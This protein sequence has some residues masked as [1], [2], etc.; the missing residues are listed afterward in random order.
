MEKL[1][2]Q[3]PVCRISFWR[4]A[5]MEA[6]TNIH[7]RNFDC[8]ICGKALKTKFALKIHVEYIHEGKEKDKCHICM[9]EFQGKHILKSHI[10]FVHEGKKP[11]LCSHCGYSSASSNL[12]RRHI[13]G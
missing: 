10:E 9:A 1:K 8:S 11:H 12:L 2:Y 3:C 4:K 6:H 13:E 5:E 7:K